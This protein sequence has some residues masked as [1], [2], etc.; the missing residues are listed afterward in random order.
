VACAV[1]SSGITG[2]AWNPFNRDIRALKAEVL[3]QD[4]AF[5]EKLSLKEKV[6][7]ESQQ[8]T[9]EYNEKK[10]ALDARLQEARLQLQ[11]L[12]KKYFEKTHD[13]N[14]TIDPYIKESQAKINTYSASLRE[15][16]RA[17]A[18]M[19]K[20]RKSM[21]RMV[22]RAQP[23]TEKK[24]WEEGIASLQKNI[25]PLEKQVAY[26]KDQLALE[27]KKLILLRER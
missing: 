10:A 18:D 24:R 8:C 23:H 15:N 7:R 12:Q 19:Q 4:P 27:R 3:E 20:S 13:L 21:E 6:R 9:Q 26:L 5:K 25:A 14:K 11:D 17:L 16:E 22:A 1:A 2:F